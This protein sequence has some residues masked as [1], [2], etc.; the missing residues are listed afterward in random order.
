MF[1]LVQNPSLRLNP[2]K[3]SKLK[4]NLHY[5]HLAGPHIFASL[6]VI[7]KK[8]GRKLNRVKLFLPCSN[9]QYLGILCIGAI[10]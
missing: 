5:I 7:F 4:S 6:N 9:R 3:W 2:L 1:C 10:K 8:K